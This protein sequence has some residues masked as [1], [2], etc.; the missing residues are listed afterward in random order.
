MNRIPIIEPV[1]CN[2]CT[3]CCHNDAIRILPNE[4]P[5][6]WKTEPHA[7]IENALMLAH[8]KN[9]DCFYL[10]SGGCSIQNAKP[11]QCMEMDCRNIARKFSYT[12]MRK[13]KA[14][15]G[16]LMAIWKR[17]KEIIRNENKNEK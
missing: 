8:K 1:P 10:G 13:N 14:V 11:I 17:G 2:G 6:Q 15:N 5:D 7:V 4:N 9:G 12:H 3:R 16:H